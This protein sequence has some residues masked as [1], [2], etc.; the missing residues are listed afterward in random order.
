MKRCVLR[1]TLFVL[2]LS[3]IPPAQADQIRVI[4]WNNL[5]MHCMDAD[6]ST[7]AIL[8]PFNE[9]HV[10]MIDSQGRLVTAPLLTGSIM[11]QAVAD[12]AGSITTTSYSKT[13]FWQYS[14]ALLG[15]SPAP[16][17]GIAG[18]AMPGSKNTL[19]ALVFQPASAWFAGIGIPIVPIDD[20]GLKNYFPMMR[21]EYLDANKTVRAQTS[22]VLPVSDEMDCSRCHASGSQPPNAMP[23]FQWVW[24]S[25]P[26]KDFKLNILK[27][28][29]ARQPDAAKYQ[30]LLAA[31]K[32]PAGLYTSA[33]NGVP[34][35]CD[36][37]HLSNAVAPLG[38][39]GIHGVPPLTM[40]V[41]TKHATVIDA[42]NGLT[43]NASNN[44]N[45]C[46]NCHPGSAT[47]CLRGA[48]GNAVAADGTMEIQCQ[49]CHGSMSAV[50]AANRQGWLQ[51]PN[52]QSC[53]TG[54][55]TNNN[56]Q[57]RYT[58]VFETSGAVRQA[59][60]DTFATNPDTPAAGISLFRFSTGH[61]GLQCEAC[62][63]ATHAEYP[64]SQANDNVQSL[65]L[66]GHVGML[67][68]CNTCHAMPDTV[69]DGPHGLHPLGQ[70]WVNAHP[71]AVE[72]NG[73]DQ[74][75]DCHGTDY[76]GTVLSYSKAD[77]TLST[78]FGT[79]FFWRGFQI[80]CYA[81][82]NGPDSDEPT[83][84][85]APVVTNTMIV[86][87]AGQSMSITLQGTDRDNNPLTFRIVSQPANGT[88]ALAGR[89][90]T[91]IPA[92][93]FKGSDVF[94][95]AAW[96]GYTNSNLGVVGVRVN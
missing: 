55:A 60:D 39:P 54:T 38:I 88:V 71:D 44:R 72:G 34:I 62:H 9:I 68:E 83:T 25:D 18:F 30:N 42:A 96:D 43:L 79:K 61:G 16:D 50:G 7:F 58:S 70:T 78:E 33:I 89:V 45:A 90:A 85:H 17:M 29:D 77:R 74:C 28:H 35:F 2:G 94:R 19:Q 92:P 4:G 24:N 67:A 86:T 26:K 1:C 12:T 10:Q 36:R 31:S 64:S 22:I 91:F 32:Y 21:I 52:C 6:F 82:H 41:H 8:P 37:C 20:A 40:S 80:G 65:N 76:R 23:P 93:G 46:Y 5:G 59:V 51:E 13:D 11:Y 95:F 48:M 3:V 27:L 57:I 69:S 56:G 14:H 15:A 66:Q 87:N 63:G 73:N 84:N 49:N 81:C 75:R 47:R 53:H